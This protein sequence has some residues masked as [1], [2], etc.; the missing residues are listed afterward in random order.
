MTQS[1]RTSVLFYKIWC[2]LLSMG[3]A[4]TILGG[5]QT[6][7]DVVLALPFLVAALFLVSL[8]DV[9]IQ[10]GTISY[11]RLLRWREIPKEQV[12]SARVVFPHLASLRLKRFLFPWGNLYFVQQPEQMQAVD[13]LLQNQ[14]PLEPQQQNLTI[15]ATHT[16]LY[17]VIAACIGFLVY[18]AARSF[19]PPSRLEHHGPST[20]ILVQQEIHA[21]LQSPFVGVVLCLV[22]VPTAIFRYRD[23]AAWIYAFLAGTSVSWLLFF[24]I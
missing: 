6:R 21:F 9:R 14:K 3:A 24:L 8:A 18:Y 20:A 15:S 2:S 16:K 1:D 7:R 5:E 4:A 13:D 11:R 10:N 19:L 23:R 22:F 17:S 12:K